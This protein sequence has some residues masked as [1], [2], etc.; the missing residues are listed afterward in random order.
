MTSDP[1][2]PKQ[3][4]KTGDSRSGDR[5]E[6]N[7]VADNQ[8]NRDEQVTLRPVTA[9]DD[10]FIFNCYASTRAQEL[11]QVPWSP[12]QKEAFVKM[13]YTAQKQ[14]YAAEAP[15][16]NHD[17][18]YVGSTPVGR[19]F[20]D[21]R[22]NALHILDITVLPQHRNQGTGALLLRRL[23]DEAGRAGKPVTIYVESFNP[24]LR[25]FERLGFLKDHEKGFHL[26]MKWQ[27]AH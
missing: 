24:S 2:T 25:F 3:T 6:G 8:K 17:I 22:D 21:R 1:A 19:I 16:A 7:Q 15:H 10:D 27:P 11:A 5:T 18:I 23:L 9:A 4:N 13:Q 20:L 12:E 14:H 26:L